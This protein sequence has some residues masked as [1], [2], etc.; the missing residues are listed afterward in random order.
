MLR[1]QR[2]LPF[3]GPSLDQFGL[4]FFPSRKLDRLAP[5]PLQLV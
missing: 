1:H 2:R 5:A 3:F 4:R